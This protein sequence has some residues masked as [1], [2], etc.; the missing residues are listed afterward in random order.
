M[1]AMRS[2]RLRLQMDDAMALDKAAGKHWR[3]NSDSIAFELW[4]GWTHWH[5][6]DWLEH[7]AIVEEY[8]SIKEEYASRFETYVAKKFRVG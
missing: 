6:Q 2:N 1:R 5:R 3:R 4:A 8:S 7:G